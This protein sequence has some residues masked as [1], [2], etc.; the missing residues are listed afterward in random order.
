MRSQPQGEYVPESKAEVI[1]RQST[2]LC[3]TFSLTLRSKRQKL[4]QAPAL[5]QRQ[6]QHPK[7]RRMYDRNTSVEEL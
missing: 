1:K 5:A 3:S 4:E 2:F 7:W 6:T